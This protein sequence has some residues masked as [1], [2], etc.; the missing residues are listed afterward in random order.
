MK[1]KSDSWILIVI[2]SLFLV[3]GLGT[4]GYMF[5][6]SGDSEENTELPPASNQYQPP[7][8][9]T[10]CSKTFLLGQDCKSSPGC[11]EKGTACSGNVF[12][13]ECKYVYPICENVLPT[14]WSLGDH[15]YEEAISQIELY[16]SYLQFY[17]LLNG[18]NNFNKDFAYEAT[19]CMSNH[20]EYIDFC[21]QCPDGTSTRFVWLSKEQIQ[22]MYCLP[23]PVG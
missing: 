4:M 5:F 7:T 16:E 13:Y 15:T 19:Q 2:I 18:Q 1:K 11:C 3:V 22:Y 9:A 12:G 8:P 23:N 14:Q 21:C 17:T 20:P 6:T 10:G